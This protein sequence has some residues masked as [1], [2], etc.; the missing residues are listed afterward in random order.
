MEADARIVDTDELDIATLFDVEQPSSLLN[1]PVSLIVHVDRTIDVDPHRIN[2]RR[3]RRV[4]GVTRRWRDLTL[5]RLK[6][7]TARLGDLD[8]F[9]VGLLKRQHL[10][11]HPV[12]HNLRLGVCHGRRRHERACHGCDTQQTHQR[13][14]HPHLLLLHR[15][16]PLPL[17]FRDVRYRLARPAWSLASRQ[18]KLTYI[19][20]WYCATACFD[21]LPLGAS[22]VPWG[23][24][25]THPRGWR[26][27]DV[28]KSRY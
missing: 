18:L 21:T 10:R 7:V 4:D 16:A 23:A 17:C 19:S 9:V 1:P 20:T 8:G 13:S 3:I 28:A 14:A 6:Y 5:S 27:H 12:G 15:S 22:C 26:V 24:N 2:P 25:G 11:P